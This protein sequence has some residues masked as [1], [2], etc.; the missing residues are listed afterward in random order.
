MAAS[1]PTLLEDTLYNISNPEHD[2]YGRYLNAESVKRLLLPTSKA[3]EATLEWLTTSGVSLETIVDDGDWIKFEAPL[4]VANRM[5]EANFQVYQSLKGTRAV[6]TLAYSV[7]ASLYDH[8]DMIHPTV[9]FSDIKEWRIPD[10]NLDGSQSTAASVTNECDPRSITPACLRELYNIPTTDS[11]DNTTTGFLA[12]AN[13]FGEYPRYEDVTS[14]VN[15]WFPVAT[16]FNWTGESIANGSID[17]ETPKKS[18]EANLDVQSMLSMAWPLRIHAY[19]TGGL[20]EFV[21][22]IDQPT[23][24]SNQNEPFLDL[25]S[26]LLANDDNELPHTISISYGEVEQSVPLR[27]RKRVCGMLGQLGLRGVSVLIASGDFGPGNSCQTNDDDKRATFEAIFPAACPY[28]TSVGATAGTSPEEGASFSSGGFSQT[29]T[30]PEYQKR[31]VSGFLSKNGNSWRGLFN[32]DGRGFPDV[33]AQGTNISFVDEG[34]RTQFDGTSASA[35]I[36]AGV[37]GL[38]NAQRLTSGKRPLGFLNPWI[39]RYGYD[40]FTDITRGGSRGCTGVTATG[41]N[42]TYVPFASW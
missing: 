28:V 34:N 2:V 30:Q 23:E 8:V 19:S 36:F 39:Y 6:R 25:L 33:A 29:W 21:P 41:R 42:G 4:H 5:L 40:G 32:P 7:P 18:Y 14:F 31:A 37:I 16:G 13:F 27:Y 1:E 17:Q 3:T 9:R 38:L 24:A 11:A 20:G 12:F 10:D 26:H 15:N 22:S 35:P